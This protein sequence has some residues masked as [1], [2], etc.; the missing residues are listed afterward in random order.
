[1][2]GGT[3]RMNDHVLKILLEMSDHELYHLFDCASNEI[4]SMIVK[5]DMDKSVWKKSRR[6]R[7]M[8]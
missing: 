3:R 2:Y 8:L 6:M 7:D 5:D 1:M 4:S